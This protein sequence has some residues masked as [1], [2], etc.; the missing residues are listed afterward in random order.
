VATVTAYTKEKSDEIYNATVV[1]G[2]IDGAGHLILEKRDESTIDAGSVVGPIGPSGP[3][4]P[5]IPPG[6]ITMWA[7][8]AAPAGYLLCDGGI[9]SR[10][11]YADLFAAIGIAYGAGDGSTTFQLPDIRSRFP[12][13]KGTDTWSDSLNEKGGSKDAILVSHD[14]DQTVH[15][16]TNN[17]DHPSVTSG[18]ENNVHQHYHT[19]NGHVHMADNVLTDKFVMVDTTGGPHALDINAGTGAF[20]FLDETTYVAA[21]TNFGVQDPKQTHTHNTDIP[22][23]TGITGP[24]AAVKTG[25]QG[26]SGTDKN[27]P[28]YITMNFIIRF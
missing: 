3:P 18:P 23:Y 28:P 22:N 24:S 21:S 20:V 16:H 7:G 13:G 26:V 27:L 17:H 1:D 14:H 4:G 9:I 12:V 25:S 10:T 8:A 11:T 2:H 5:G 15:S 19:D 6:S